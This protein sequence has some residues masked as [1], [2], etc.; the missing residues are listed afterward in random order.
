MGGHIPGLFP[1]TPSTCVL[2]STPLRTRISSLSTIKSS[3]E[4]LCDGQQYL[5]S[6]HSDHPG[7]PW[8]SL[9]LLA[10]SASTFSSEPIV[11]SNSPLPDP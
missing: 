11:H 2:A 8:I 4:G 1:S 7:V 9:I 6:P 10:M 3:I 5:S